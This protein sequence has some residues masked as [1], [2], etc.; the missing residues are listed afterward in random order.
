MRDDELDFENVLTFDELAQYARSGDPR[1]LDRLLENVGTLTARLVMLRIALEDRLAQPRLK[2]YPPAVFVAYKW[3]DE[4]HNAWVG[5]LARHLEGRGY[6]VL[7]DRD[8]LEQDASNYDEVPGYIARLV[9]CDYCLVVV[10]ERYLDLVEVRHEK[11]SWVYDEYEAASRLHMQGRLQIVALLKESTVEPDNLLL[12]MNAI[13]MRR[14]PNDYAALDGRFPPYQGPRLTE[15]GRRLLLAFARQFDELMAADEPDVGAI[16]QILTDNADFEPL[17]DYRLRVAEVYWRAGLPDQAYP[18][19][20]AIRDECANDD[21]IMLLAQIFDAA[22]DYPTLFKFLYQARSRF[23]LQGSVTYHY[24]MAETLLELNSVVA[25]LNH[26]RWLRRSA[27]FEDMPAHLRDLISERIETL[28]ETVGA[29]EPDH[30]FRC[31]ACEAQYIHAGELN[32]V[33]GDC[34]TLYDST[35]A[36]CP[37]CANDGRVPLAILLAGVDVQVLCPICG[38]GS[39]A[40]IAD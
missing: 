27:A 6:E 32:V 20:L 19:A 2:N 10:T 11:T 7:L 40:V 30:R 22:H 37:V 29:V 26:F 16:Q 15:D 17:Y 5:D 12:R 33:C 28:D 35:D 39:M 8:H 31:T 9:D 34:G 25:A 14:T 4:A 24:F 23:H 18:V 13:D 3:E 38:E 21:D 36:R 1:A